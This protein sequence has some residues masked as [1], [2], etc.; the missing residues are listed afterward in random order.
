MASMASMASMAAPSKDIGVARLPVRRAGTFAFQTSETQPTRRAAAARVWL[1]GWESHLPAPRASLAQAVGYGR[2]SCPRR[3]VRLSRKPAGRRCAKDMHPLCIASCVYRCSKDI[4]HALPP[5]PSRC[6]RS[7][8]DVPGSPA[9]PRAA[10]ARRRRC[11]NA[12]VSSRPRH[13]P[14]DP[15]AAALGR[16]SPA[17]SSATASTCA[18]MQQH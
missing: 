10:V 9:V 7:V 2:A 3:G 4:H 18:A 17:E 6:E 15:R 13:G 8:M 11:R 14:A 5:Q 16:D 12:E 1:M